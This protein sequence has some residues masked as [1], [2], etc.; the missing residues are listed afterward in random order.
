MVGKLA[1]VI[2]AG[3]VFA[4]CATRE[5]ECHD[6]AVAF[7]ECILDY[8]DDNPKPFCDCFRAGSGWD[9]NRCICLYDADDAV[10]EEACVVELPGSDG[11]D[12][13]M[14]TL[15]RG[16]SEPERFARNPCYDF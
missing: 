7:R 13:S 6:A 8:C 14:L 5:E 1:V 2:I 3:T 4:G 15:E 11:L 16:C 12:R 9:S 10:L